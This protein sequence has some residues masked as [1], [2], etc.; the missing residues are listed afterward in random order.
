MHSV[1]DFPIN[2][3]FEAICKGPALIELSDEVIRDLSTDQHYGYRIVM[4]IRN[5]SVSEQLGSLEIGPVNHSRWLTTANRVLR[6]Y[7]SLHD[8]EESDSQNL[9]LLA[10]FIVGVYYPC[11][12][13]IKVQ[14]KWIEGP[15]HVLFQIKCLKSQDEVVREAVIP[16]VKRSAWYIQSEHIIQ[17]L[18]CSKEQEERLIGIEKLKV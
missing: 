16:S 17:T 2:P 6:L 11:W 14:H 9:R 13:K 8:L 7:V 10:E 18:L 15:R 4:A 12:F 3:D 1:T 5:G